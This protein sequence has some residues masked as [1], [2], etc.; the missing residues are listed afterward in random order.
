MSYIA[1]SAI[2]L[3]GRQVLGGT[4]AT[5]T[6]S[7]IP[8]NFSHLKLVIFG[9]SN[10]AGPNATIKYVIN[11]DTGANYDYQLAYGVNNTSVGASA[12]IATATDQVSAITAATA[13]ANYSGVIESMF[14]CYKNTTFYK[15]F[16][17]TTSYNSASLA[18]CQV[19]D[20]VNTWRSTSAI[21]SIAMSDTGGGSFI[22]G[23]SFY[24]YGVL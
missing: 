24:L 18:N 5:V 14:F 13:S 19:V 11:G 3:I 15:S 20:L 6:F 21:T 16:K 23:S 2:Q 12:V 4:S 8:Q 17:T 7:S 1:G 10:Y 22:A 9:R